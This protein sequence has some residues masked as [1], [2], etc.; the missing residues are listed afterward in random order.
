MGPARASGGGVSDGGVR[1]MDRPFPS[2]TLLRSG[3]VRETAALRERTGAHAVVLLSQLTECQRR[4]LSAAFGCPA[5]SLAD[6]RAAA[7]A[8]R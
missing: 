6:C 2:R 5:V 8:P 7:P 1:S 3:K 4:V